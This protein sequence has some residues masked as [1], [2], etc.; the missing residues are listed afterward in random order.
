MKES[1]RLRRERR[2]ME[3]MV[4]VFCTGVHRREPDECATCSDFL[5]YA[6]KRVEKCPYQENKPP[7]AKCPTS[8]SLGNRASAPAS[9]AA[10]PAT[11]SPRV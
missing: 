6:H 8:C 7:C 11:S 10:M 5:K 4:R 9:S 2:T 1:T 3:A